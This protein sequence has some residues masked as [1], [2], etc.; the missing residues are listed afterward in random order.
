MLVEDF[1]SSLSDTI[2]NIVA[3]SVSEGNKNFEIEARIFTS[4]KRLDRRSSQRRQ[5]DNF[6]VS[7]DHWTKL[8]TALEKQ[9]LSSKSSTIRTIGFSGKPHRFRL[10]EE[11]GSRRL[12]SELKHNYIVKSD[13]EFWTRYSI[14]E[15]TVQDEQALTKITSVPLSRASL[16][17]NENFTPADTRF[18]ESLGKNVAV[19]EQEL[20]SFRN[21]RFIKRTSFT[22]TSQAYKDLAR[23]DMSEVFS[24]TGEPKYEVEVEMLN[25]ANNYTR[26]QDFVLF[27]RKVVSLFRGTE[28]SY[29]WS[30]YREFCTMVNTLVPIAEKVLS[31][32][33]VNKNLFNQ[34]R[35]I[36]KLDLVQGGLVGGQI[37][38]G[39]SYKTD[40][41]RSIL[42]LSGF[43]IWI[44]WPPYTYNLISN[45]ALFEDREITI[46][47]GECIPL[48]EARKDPNDRCKYVYEVFDAI[49]VRGINVR[50]LDLDQRLS[51]ARDYLH[52][53]DI[54]EILSTLL[55]IRIKP[56]WSFSTVQEFFNKVET[57]LVAGEQSDYKTDGLV[58]TPWNTGYWIGIDIDTEST[59]RT[60]KE[61]H[62]IV[63]WKNAKNTTIDFRYKIVDGNPVLAVTEWEQEPESG[64]KLAKD[65]PFLGDS[66]YPFNQETMVDWEYIVKNVREDSIGEYSFDTKKKKFVFLRSRDAKAHPNTNETV[67]I[68]NW[69]E[70]NSP[71]TEEAITGKSFQLMF[72]Y[73]SRIKSDLMNKSEGT[74]LDIGSGK[75]GVIWRWT[76]YKKIVAVEPNGNHIVEF[77]RRC[78]LAGLLVVEENGEVPV[79][80]VRFVI[81]IHGKAEETERIQKQVRRIAPNGVNAVSLMDVGTF[82]WQN[83][84][85]LNKAL[86]TIKSCLAPG[87][88]FLWKMLNGDL[89]RGVIDKPQ[90][91]GILEY[92]SFRLKYTANNGNLNSQVE[93][94]IP[95]GITTEGDTETEFQTEWLTSI[96]EME[97]YFPS[98]DYTIE[99]RSIADQEAFMSENSQKLSALFEYGIIK[100]KGEI[101]APVAKSDVIRINRTSTATRGRGRGNPIQ[102][103]DRLPGASRGRG[104]LISSMKRT[105]PPLAATSSA[106][107]EQPEK[108]T[109]PKVFDA[110]EI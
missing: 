104:S 1:V 93:V 109:F 74:L 69:R 33:F 102:N 79:E 83:T 23:I 59:S 38:Y 25:V 21:E 72:Y 11:D 64:E 20:R 91:E 54:D 67:A 101:E 40:A 47:D 70:I 10:I 48:G 107:V 73:H 85:I 77:R 3:K 58:F 12:V 71:I 76:K 18:L 110:S 55:R 81:L 78:Q 92:G 45:K 8:K 39:V 66:M 35:T 26:V 17:K 9:G 37:T 30:I 97:T 63:K 34:V 44:L 99:S 15:E 106:T 57:A 75:G 65:I 89:V 13:D 43:G 84:T 28:V 80:D 46:L 86:E 100:K 62:E 98:P 14:S 108:R 61:K 53:I 50:P 29:N 94:F 88:L 68:P 95:E 6:F 32:D 90:E 87:G 41:E 51:I 24:S 96:E 60:L 4:K 42:V 82:F 52:A 36:K 22:A 105:R 103:R 16:N 5:E 27:C 19:L 49:V 31:S 7:L 2:S 56:I